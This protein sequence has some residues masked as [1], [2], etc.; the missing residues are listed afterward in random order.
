MENF[1]FTPFVFL[2]VFYLYFYVK[3]FIW[4]RKTTNSEI[5]C[6]L[7]FLA[8]SISAAL[9]LCLKII[10]ILPGTISLT[11]PCACLSLGWIIVSAGFTVCCHTVQLFCCHVTRIIG[12]EIWNMVIYRYFCAVPVFHSVVSSIYDNYSSPISQLACN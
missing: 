2:V 9:G 4:R 1:D 8:A 3:S 10:E 5:I 12:L 6:S 11:N 7:L